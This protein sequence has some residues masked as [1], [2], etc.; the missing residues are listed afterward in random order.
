MH[1]QLRTVTC[2]GLLM[3]AHVVSGCAWPGPQV[4]AISAVEVH[5][6]S[7]FMCMPRCRACRA[8]RSVLA[9]DGQ[10]CRA[11]EWRAP[12]LC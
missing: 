11:G 6:K 1:R 10:Q 12:R 9:S 5:E 4:S 7:T 2:A 8:A 3:G